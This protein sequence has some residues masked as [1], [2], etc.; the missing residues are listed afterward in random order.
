MTSHRISLKNEKPP[1]ILECSRL[2]LNTVIL[3]V[4]VLLTPKLMCQ[5]SNLI[6]TSFHAIIG[7]EGAIPA[8]GR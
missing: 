4:F 8:K 3:L 6:Q 1:T 7:W 5:F 2:S